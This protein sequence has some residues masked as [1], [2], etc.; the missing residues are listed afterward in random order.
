M[1]S[2]ENK[3]LVEDMLSGEIDLFDAMSDDAI[4]QVASRRSFIGKASIL[5]ELVAPLMNLMESMGTIVPTNI[6]AEGDH[7]V[8]EGYAEGRMTKRG[9]AYNN[10]YCIVY[11]FRDGKIVHITE[12]ADLTLAERV[13]PELDLAEGT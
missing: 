11:R 10:N 5:N 4:W 1:S 8:L 13:L 3:K 9:E 6:V 7:V 12:Y 2:E